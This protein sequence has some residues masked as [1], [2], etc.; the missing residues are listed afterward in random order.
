MHIT[1]QV[2][3]DFRRVFFIVILSVVVGLFYVLLVRPGTPY[4]EPQHFGMIRYYSSFREMPIMG[5]PGVNYQAF[6]PPIYYLLNGFLYRVVGFCGEK[7]AFYII[8]FFS[9]LLMMPTVFISF[10][11]ASLVCGADRVLP[12]S[13][14][15]F[16]GLNPSLLAIASSVQNDML[17]IVLSLWAIYLTI[18]SILSYKSTFCRTLILGVLVATAIL[19]KLTAIFLIISI[20]LCFLVIRRKCAYRLIGIFL[21]VIL[22]IG[23]WWFAR[24]YVLYGDLTGL[25]AHMQYFSVFKTIP[26]KPIDLLRWLGSVVVYLWLPVEYY[27]NLIHAGWLRLIVVTYM[28]LGV[29]GWVYWFRARI[30]FSPRAWMPSL[31]VWLLAIHFLTC[32]SLYFLGCL[33]QFMAPARLTLP[34]IVIPVMLICGGG[35]FAFKQFHHLGEKAFVVILSVSLITTNACILW[36]AYHLSIYPFHL[37]T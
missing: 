8:R 10:R 16:I 33:T 20:P 25:N 6:Q 23:G 19:T 30:R 26:W 32:V 13:T 29:A 17:A 7:N 3:Y 1:K 31:V 4:D 35:L 14:A 18:D 12:L 5:H 21:A 15:I 36:N 37:F 9:L 34:T 11:I 28:L 2:D 22:I 24:N 27:R